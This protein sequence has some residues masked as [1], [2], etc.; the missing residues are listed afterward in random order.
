MVLDDSLSEDSFIYKDLVAIGSSVTLMAKK[1]GYNKNIFE[2]IGLIILVINFHNSEDRDLFHH[3]IKSKK[4]SD[5]PVL[6][7]V[8]HP[9]SKSIQGKLCKLVKVAGASI[10]FSPVQ[11]GEFNHKIKILLERN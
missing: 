6:I 11:A 9:L 5:L 7:I 10:L 1:Q 3:F 8:N 2:L 4:N